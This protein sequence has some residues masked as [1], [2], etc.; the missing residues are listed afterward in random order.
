MKTVLAWL[1]AV[2]GFVLAATA[3]MVVFQ[4][5]LG[6]DHGVV[7]VTA[8]LALGGAVLGYEAVEKGWDRLFGHPPE[9]PA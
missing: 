4:E 2:V 7:K 1:A 5:W 8:P 3:G 6:W 9:D